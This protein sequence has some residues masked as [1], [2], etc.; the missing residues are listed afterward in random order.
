M[1]YV[2]GIDIG[3]THIK[4]GLVNELGELVRTAIEDNP[5]D[6]PTAAGDCYSAE[7]VWQL[8]CRA[9]K[10]VLDGGPWEICA[11]GVTSM[12]D[13][14]LPV[15]K[16]G[17]PLTPVI[18]WNNCSGIEYAPQVMER[19]PDGALYQ[20]TGQRYHPK[21][22]LSRILALKLESPEIFNK[23][24]CW[25]SL[26]DYILYRLTGAWVT[27]KTLACRT[28]LYDIRKQAWDPSMLEFTGMEGRLPRVVEMGEAAGGLLPELAEEWGMEP[29]VPVV[30]GG[31]DHLCAA[32]AAGIS[33]GEVLNS[34]GTSEVFIG[35][36]NHPNHDPLWEN[37]GVNQGCYRDG[38]F[39]WLANLPSSGASV[40]WLRGLLSINGKI[41]Y[42]LFDDEE[43]LTDSHGVLYVPRINGS[44]T[45]CPD[46]QA[47][48][49]FLGLTADTTVHDMIQ[50][51]YEGI[52]YQTRWILESVAELS[53][54]MPE[55]VIAA[56]GGVRNRSLVRAK[57]DV[58]GAAYQVSRDAELTL[59]GAA[60]QAAQAAGVSMA[61]CRR[62]S[63]QQPD[64][65][66]ET[67]YSTGYR[68]YRAVAEF[69]NHRAL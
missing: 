41:G 63:V 67:F 31:H 17:A 9:V 34:M 37:Y 20:M 69:F 52:A 44:G 33:G 57:A 3:T 18:P 30:C 66:K 59:L 27:D 14:G 35:L 55:R 13:S 65:S 15:D 23:T 62:V 6:T 68:E 50:A 25:L 4:A 42:S 1:R 61:H 7:H 36:S 51:M 58:T 40:E 54:V 24:A 28:L 12:A 47:K 64:T 43:S 39:Y 26:Y 21:F 8:A 22:A 46:P 19:F 56:G 53:G 5:R 38:L 11:V 10:K 49:M 48:G 16:D 45:P 29:G 32:Y 2:V 60:V